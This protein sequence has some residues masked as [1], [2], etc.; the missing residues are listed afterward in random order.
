MITCDQAVL[1][2]IVKNPVFDQYIYTQGTSEIFNSGKSK[3]IKQVLR[4]VADSTCYNELDSRIQKI[5]SSVQNLLNSNLSHGH[6]LI[7]NTIDC[8]EDPKIKI[9]TLHQNI[10]MCHGSLKDELPEQEIFAQFIN[11]SM[12]VLEIG[13]N[14]GRSTLTIAS[15]ISTEK[16][17]VSLECDRFSYSKL[18]DNILINNFRPQIINAALSKR[19]LIQKGW[20]TKPSDIDEPGWSTVPI[21]TLEVIKTIYPLQFN[22]LVLDCEGAFYYILLDFPEIMEGIETVFIEND[23]KEIKQKEYVDHILLSLG[24]V[25]IFAR[26]APYGPTPERFYEV[27]KKN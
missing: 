1:Q 7:N 17:L 13:A 2:S 22:T 21:V 18:R 26:P 3:V 4:R 10:R 6:D 20:D 9:D 8:I 25:C 16:N 23:F 12:I 11:P 15:I 5:A 14:L 27:W 19:R 24:F